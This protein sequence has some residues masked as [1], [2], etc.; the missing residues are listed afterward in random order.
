M[1]KSP[2]EA[3]RD[4]CPFH[5]REHH[6][7]SESLVAMAKNSWSS[8]Y[9]RL[10]PTFDEA[11]PATRTD[12]GEKLLVSETSY[13]CRLR[14]STTLRLKVRIEQRLLPAHLLGILQEVYP[15]HGHL[16]RYC[17]R[18][19][20][21]SLCKRFVSHPFRRTSTRSAT[22]T[23]LLIWCDPADDFWRQIGCIL[24]YVETAPETPDR[25]PEAARR[26]HG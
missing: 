8:H 12:Q 21:H 5:L 1:E 17:R 3:R 19:R 16:V 24:G 6:Y 25:Q 14:C 13:Q 23:D 15:S 26:T 20:R 18:G 2:S 10:V 22:P 7:L 11:R 4:P 9:V